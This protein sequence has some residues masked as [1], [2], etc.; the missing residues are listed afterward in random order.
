MP[1]IGPYT[2]S[3]T[4][5]AAIAL[6]ALTPGNT[7]PGAV[8]LEPMAGTA[9]APGAIE[10]PAPAPSNTAPGVLPLADMTPANDS[11]AGIPL[12]GFTP[13]DDA[14]GAIPLDAFT[15]SNTPPSAIPLPGGQEPAPSTDSVNTHVLII[16]GALTLNA[17]YGQTEIPA[18]S[19]LTEVQWVLESAPITGPATVTLVDGTGT[20]LNVSVTIEAGETFG[21]VTLSK[22][23]AE[24]LRVRAKC[25][26]TPGGED[27]GAFGVVT[28]FTRRA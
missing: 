4:P 26:A 21:K 27:P 5:P 23:L 6:P 12:A 25:T 28:L 2:P 8:A 20:S 10:L 13:G 17:T 3:N 18:A 16:P 15:P 11:P 22:S 1:T 14:P 7:P 9:S 24:G 19:T